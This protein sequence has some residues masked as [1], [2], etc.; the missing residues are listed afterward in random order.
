VPSE[1]EQVELLAA[2]LETEQVVSETESP[3]PE[4]STVLPTV[5][6]DVLNVAVG[7]VP[8]RTVKLAEAES[9]PGLPT[10]VIV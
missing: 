1:I 2:S 7:P 6:D 5:A 4:I 8:V 10:T 9:L 3:E